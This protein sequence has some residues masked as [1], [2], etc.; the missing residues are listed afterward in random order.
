MGNP[1]GFQIISIVIIR[2]KCFFLFIGREPTT[3]PANNCLQIMV[4]SCAMSSNSVWLQRIFCS[5]VNE[6]TLFSFLRSLLGENDRSLHFPKIF[7]KKTNSVIEWSNDKTIIEL[8]YRKISWFVH[9][10]YCVSSRDVCKS[11][12]YYGIKMLSWAHGRLRVSCLLVR[13]IVPATPT[14]QSVSRSSNIYLISSPQTN[15]DILLNL[16]Q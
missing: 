8:G 6:T 7:L 4:C 9:V 16:V 1:T 10:M 14:L 5:C 11:I 13:W 3:W 2:C 12:T 15:R